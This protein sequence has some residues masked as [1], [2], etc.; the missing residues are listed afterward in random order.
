MSIRKFELY[1]GAVLVKIVRRSK[2]LTLF[3][4]GDDT[5]WAAYLVNDTACIYVKTSDQRGGDRSGAARFSYTFQPA[6]L[7]FLAEQRNTRGPACVFAAL[8]CGDKEVALV[9]VDE[10]ARCID[11]GA[12]TAQN[13]T[14]LVQ[15]GQSLRV[16]GPLNGNAGPVPVARN[17]IDT[18]DLPC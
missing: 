15:A 5:A 9:T 12:T 1:H 14:V 11:L 16:Y 2:S 4:R 18:Y 10:L 17:R 3:E 7:G 13:M 8:V 6:E